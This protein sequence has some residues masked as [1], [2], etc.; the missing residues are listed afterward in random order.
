MEH[1]TGSRRMLILGVLAG[2][3]AIV[4]VLILAIGPGD[5]ATPMR[6]GS[7]GSPSGDG[8]PV[9][10]PTGVLGSA[11]DPRAAG[12]VMACAMFEDGATVD[13]F[14]IW[15]EADIGTVGAA[16][17]EMFREILLEALTEACPEVLDR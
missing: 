3:V 15:F 16:E 14:A 12:V 8:S 13:D 5:G 9:L 11:E 6:N 2:A 10:S 17:E 1:P 7:G 4:T